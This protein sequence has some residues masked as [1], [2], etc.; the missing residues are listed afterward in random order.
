MNRLLL[1]AVVLLGILTLTLALRTGTSARADEAAGV[2]VRVGDTVEVEGG[3]VGCKVVR[4]GDRAT[5]DCRRAGRLAGSYGTLLDDRRARVVRF[6][7]SRSAKVVFTAQH[8]GS[9]RRCEK[10]TKARR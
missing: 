3:A 5:L 1:I 9:S 8:R 4:K 10:E 6:Q 7:S 2:V